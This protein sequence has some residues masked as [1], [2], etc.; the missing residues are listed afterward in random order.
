MRI[1]A[2]LARLV[3]HLLPRAAA[4]EP[5]PIPAAGRLDRPSHRHRLLFGCCPAVTLFHQAFYRGLTP[6]CMGGYDPVHLAVISF[7]TRRK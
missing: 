7:R 3:K 5:R 1:V 4:G 6:P 2:A